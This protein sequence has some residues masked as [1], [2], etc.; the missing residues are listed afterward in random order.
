[1]QQNFLCLVDNM[2]W[3]KGG[4]NYVQN[5]N[6]AHRDSTDLH[7]SDVVLQPGD[8]REKKIV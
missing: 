4:Y 1:M 2:V 3:P 5:Y 8:W 7:S 6:P